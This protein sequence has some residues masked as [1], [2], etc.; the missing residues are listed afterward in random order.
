MKYMVISQ[1]KTNNYPLY[2]VHLDL[3]CFILYNDESVEEE[4]S[5][6]EAELSK[7][8]ETKLD[9]KK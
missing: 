3:A 9:A 5:H 7:R 2:Y 1:E 6:L 8:E 4:V